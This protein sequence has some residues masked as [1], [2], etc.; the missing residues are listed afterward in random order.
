MRELRIYCE[1]GGKGAGAKD[2]IR[3][4]L[5]TFLQPIYD[6]A[7]QKRIRVEVI[8]C[9][10]RNDAYKDFKN[11]LRAHPNSFNVLLIDTEAPV[12]E[13]S[14]LLNP[15]EQLRL[16]DEWGSLGCN[17]DQC[18]LMVQA[19][20]AWFLADRDR[21]QEFYGQGFNANALPANR[22]VEQIPKDELEPALKRASKNTTKGEYKK[23]KHRGKLLEVI[24]QSE[25]RKLSK[26]CDRLFTTLENKLKEPS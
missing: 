13:T 9:R 17:P 12:D 23:V 26:H 22:Q 6:I 10:G 21:L 20:E 11:A 15:W 8:P 16:K 7:S 2:P 3:N 1:G 18:Y 5:R 19:M 14:S 4:G 24:R 25:V